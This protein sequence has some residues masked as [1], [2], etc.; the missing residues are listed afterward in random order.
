MLLHTR[1][2]F[3]N[4]IGTF[5]PDEWLWKKSYHGWC[6]QLTYSS[7]TWNFKCWLIRRVCGVPSWLNI[8]ATAKLHS[9]LYAQFMVFRSLSV[10]LHC[11]LASCGAVY[12]YRSCLWRR[13]CGCVCGGRAVSEPYYSQR[14]QCLRLSEHFFDIWNSL[15]SNAV[16][17]TSLA[18][19][20]RSISSTDFFPSTL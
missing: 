16:D 13:V 20:K 14:A 18:S 7:I 2:H 17:F 4:R 6:Y 9:P 3:S 1:E 8:R 10:L 11:A 12:C 15:P 5:A 19:F